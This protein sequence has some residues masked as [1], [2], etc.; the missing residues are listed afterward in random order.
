MEG[1]PCDDSMPMFVNKDIDKN[2]GRYEAMTVA[3]YR[4]RVKRIYEKVLEW[5]KNSKDK[6]LNRFYDK[7]TSMNYSWGPH[8]FRHWY[9]VRLVQYGCDAV[10]IKDFRG[11]KEIT[12]SETYLKEKGSLRKEFEH[13]SDELGLVLKGIREV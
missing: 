1:K 4:E 2:T 10:Q 8:S 13:K 12:S 11:D 3:G 9:T 5:C 7:M 6:E